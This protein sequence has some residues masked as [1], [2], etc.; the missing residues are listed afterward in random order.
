LT[1]VERTFVDTPSPN[2][3][4]CSCSSVHT[5]PGTISFIVVLLDNSG[6]NG[7]GNPV[8]FTYLRFASVSVSTCSSPILAVILVILV[9]LVVVVV[10]L[11]SER[12]TIHPLAVHFFPFDAPRP[13]IFTAV[14][15]LALIVV[16]VNDTCQQPP[17][18][19]SHTRGRG[20]RTNERP[21]E[22]PNVRTNDGIKTPSE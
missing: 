15:P 1:T 17:I 10:V 13:T 18:Q 20:N 6:T 11:L 8:K 21:T 4:P 12:F 5:D 19:S 22:R 9:N 14:A 16:I 2:P 3:I 7:N